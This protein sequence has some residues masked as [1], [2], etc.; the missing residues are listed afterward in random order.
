IG[1]VVLDLAP[2]AVEAAAAAMAERIGAAHPTA[3]LEGFAVQPMV[4]AGTGIELIAGVVDDPQFGPVILFGHGGTAVEVLDDSVIALPPL[5]LTLA[6]D[7]IQRTRVARL[8]AGYRN[9]PAVDLDALALV[10][11]RLSQLVID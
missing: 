6:A 7:A 3:R 11:V 4:N 5:N 9:V 8:L 10:L 1:G 2:A